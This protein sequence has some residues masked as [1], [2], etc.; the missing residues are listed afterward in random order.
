MLTAIGD[1]MRR[2]YERG[3]ITTR[4]GNISLRKREGTHLFI[5]PSGWRKTIVHPEHVVRLEIV[6]DSLTG[7]LVPMVQD[8]QQPSGELWM[9]WNL[10]RDTAK[11]RTVVHVHATH[12]VAAI[13]AGFDLQ[14]ISA[15]FPEISRYTRVGP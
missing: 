5:T 4:D 12:I 7:E 13:Y 8:G 6:K 14:A 10:Q 11:T 2:V 9:H 1:V 15:E 3:W